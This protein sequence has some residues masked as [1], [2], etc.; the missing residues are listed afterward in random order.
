MRKK[1]IE[2]FQARNHAKIYLNVWFFTLNSL[3]YIGIIVNVS[4]KKFEE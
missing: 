1:L 2:K 3:G 4:L